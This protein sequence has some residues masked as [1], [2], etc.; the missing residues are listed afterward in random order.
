M[1]FGLIEM[2]EEQLYLHLILDII[3]NFAV[4]EKNNFAFKASKKKLKPRTHS[5][6][7]RLI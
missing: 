4:E 5:W 7:S 6:Y 2:L 1:M 3:V